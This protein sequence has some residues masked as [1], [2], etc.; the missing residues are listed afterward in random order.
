MKRWDFELMVKS[1]AVALLIAL[2]VRGGCG[3]I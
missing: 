3:N 1:L 2:L